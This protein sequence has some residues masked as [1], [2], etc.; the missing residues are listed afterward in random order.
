MQYVERYCEQY[1]F[2]RDQIPSIRAS[3]EHMYETT[4]HS[5]DVHGV[6]WVDP[7]PSEESE[8]RRRLMQTAY[9]EAGIEQI[10]APYYSKPKADTS[11]SVDSTRD[12]ISAIL[13]PEE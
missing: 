1:G 2:T 3:F 5:Q 10:I 13:Q 4:A 9:E 7:V 6:T 11:S 8:Q 12:D